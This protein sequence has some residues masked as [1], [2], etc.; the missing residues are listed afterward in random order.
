MDI[1]NKFLKS[2]WLDK[3]QQLTKHPSKVLLLLTTFRKYIKKNGF[4]SMRSD[5]SVLCNYV[6]DIMERR[7]TEY[8]T[9]DLVLIVAAII[10]VVTPMDIVPDFLFMFGL[11]DDVAIVGWAINHLNAEL[12]RYRQW[13][14]EKECS[15]EEIDRCP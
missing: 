9:A 11:I 10:Y 1:I 5:L 4:E 6:K 3:A 2:S 13:L 15:V 8:K 12:A 7:Y 14:S